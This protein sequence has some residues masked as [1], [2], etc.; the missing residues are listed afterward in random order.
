M[1][2]CNL[3]QA[4]FRICSISLVNCFQM[5]YRFIRKGPTSSKRLIPS[6]KNLNYEERLKVLDLTIL[7]ERG[8]IIQIIKIYHGIDI[9]EKDNNFSF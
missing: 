1:S 6:L 2:K 5:L 3:D 8:D 7:S 9:I 4:S